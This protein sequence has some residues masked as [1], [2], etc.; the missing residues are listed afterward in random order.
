MKSR[1]VGLAWRI[2]ALAWLLTCLNATEADEFDGDAGLVAVRR[3]IAARRGHGAAWRIESEVLISGL[4]LPSSN[5]AGDES[6]ASIVEN[7]VFTVDLESRWFLSEVT[8]DNFNSRTRQWSKLTSKMGFDG[9]LGIQWIPTWSDPTLSSVKRVAVSKVS[10]GHRLLVA[11][12][13]DPVMV[14]LGFFGANDFFDDE[15]VPLQKC[16]FVRADRD[17]VVLEETSEGETRTYHF[18][19]SHGL[20]LVKEE[21]NMRRNG[22]VILAQVRTIEYSHNGELYIPSLIV[23]ESPTTGVTR[24]TTFN[25]WETAAALTEADVRPPEGFLRPGM[26]VNEDTGATVAIVPLI[27]NE[28]LS[29]VPFRANGELNPSKHTRWV[30]FWIGLVVSGLIYWRR[31]IRHR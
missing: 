30:W 29:P 11:K 20:N 27:L 18:S 19:K 15:R 1:N 4:T 13:R 12:S 25:A 26:L 22:Q 3:A 28:N 24:L 16:E 6:S 9:A 23:A 7:R 31:S 21:T 8:F 14:W 17:E 10:L 5:E 2:V